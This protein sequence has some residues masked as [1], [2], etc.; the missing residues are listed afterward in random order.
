[1]T[2][3]YG[4]LAAASK[5]TARDWETTFGRWAQPPGKTEQQRCDNAV[6]AIRNAIDRSDKLRRRRV[7]VFPQGSYRNRVNVRQ[8]SDVDVGVMCH[9]VFLSYYPP[10]K[11]DADFGNVA[12]HYPFSQFKDELEE[13][14]VE[15]FGRAAVRRGNKAI[16]VHETSYHVEADVVPVFEYRHYRDNGT[17]LCGVGLIPDRGDRI[18][19]YPERLLDDW[20]RINQHYENGIEKNT[21]TGRAFKGVVRILKSLRNEMDDAGIA[22]AKPIPGFLVECLTWNAPN[23]CFQHDSWDAAVRAVLIHLWSNTKDDHACHEWTEVN[24]IKYLFR[25]GQP[26]TRS[27]AHAFIDAAWTYIGVQG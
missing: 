18:V 10:G 20:P 17:Y 9:D 13:A 12:G 22:A 26:W 15:Y 6:S 25:S 14:L 1:M 16:D 19:N 21:A 7:R 24:D 2:D 3:L 8:D 5:G 27:E 4:L 23:S 11:T